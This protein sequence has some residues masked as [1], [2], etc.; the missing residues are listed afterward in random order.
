MVLAFEGRGGFYLFIFKKAY[1]SCSFEV[2][3]LLP[4]SI[5]GSGAG[6]HFS[7]LLPRPLPSVGRGLQRLALGSRQETWGL[8]EGCPEA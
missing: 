4:T 3:R 6:Q 5:P 7:S 1:C 2:C 8:E